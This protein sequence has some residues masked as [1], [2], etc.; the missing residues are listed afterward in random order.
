[1]NLPITLPVLATGGRLTLAGW[2]S[3]PVIAEN[4][5]PPSCL[6]GRYPPDVT[7]RQL[8]A[9]HDSLPGIVEEGLC[10]WFYR[11]A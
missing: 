4:G 3:L 2:T 11:T 6:A 8:S 7:A 10:R 1:M 5:N 9:K